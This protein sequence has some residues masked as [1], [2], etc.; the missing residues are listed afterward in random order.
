M[1][2]ARHISDTCPPIG[3]DRPPPTA[4]GPPMTIR[5]PQK[6]RRKKKRSH[7]P[8]H[9]V[10]GREAH[11]RADPP[12]RLRPELD[13]LTPM[14]HVQTTTASALAV[15]RAERNAAARAIAAT[16][17]RL[18]AR[19]TGLPAMRVSRYVAGKGAD[20]AATHYI[21]LRYVSDLIPLTPPAQPP[22][23]TKPRN[24]K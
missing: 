8:A 9:A 22:P 6:N 12:L 5:E 20:D 19:S 1:R 18:A 23:T 17:I 21:M 11:L 2:V 16:G 24:I 10:R 7:L 14:Q 4:D 3:D 15:Y 13:T